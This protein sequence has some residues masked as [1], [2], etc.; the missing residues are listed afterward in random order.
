MNALIDQL[1]TLR[2]HGMASV[3]GSCI[4]RHF[5]TIFAAFCQYSRLSGLFAW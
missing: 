5:L 2:L 4:A 1:T 3:D